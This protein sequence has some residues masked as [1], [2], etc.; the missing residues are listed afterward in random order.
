MKMSTTESPGLLARG[1]QPSQ[2]HWK[3]FALVVAHDLK[4]PL[5]NVASCSRMLASLQDAENEQ[6]QQIARWLEGSAERMGAMVDGLLE[7]ARLGREPLGP[8]V[9]TQAMAEEVVM[10]LRC[11]IGRSNGSIEV[12]GLPT[13]QVGPLGMRIILVNLF[14][15]ALKYRR[16]EEPV[17]IMATAQEVEGGWEFCVRDNGM[18]MSGEQMDHVFEPFRRFGHEVD[19][20]GMGLT[21]VYQII[22]GHKGWINL[23]ST[24]GK[25]TEFRFFLPG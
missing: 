19:G 1:V 10:D 12:S 18:G 4:E 22:E 6:A 23:S 8:P 15:N 25:G 2:D 11:L 21:H 13:L 3:R 17:R 14:E 7:H 24:L 9:D 5:R 16:P 20:L